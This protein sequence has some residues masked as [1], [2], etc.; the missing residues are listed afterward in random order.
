MQYSITRRALALAALII[1]PQATLI[2]AMGAPGWVRWFSVAAGLVGVALAGLWSWGLARRIKSLTGFV[3][4]L[5][6]L[7]STPPKLKAGNDELGELVH[8]L[9]DVAPQ[10]GEL[11]NQLSTELMR[12]EAILASMTDAIV[13]VDARLNVTFC[14]Q[15]FV[16]V[17]GSQ[18]NI[19]GVALIRIVRDPGLNQVVKR[20]VDSGETI[21]TRLQPFAPGGLAFDIYAAPLATSGWRGAIAILHDVTPLE[22]L[23]RAKRDFVA[24]VSHEFR[25]PLATI[26][27]FAETLLDGGLED[28]ANRRRFVE[29]IQANGAR[30]N[31]I[32]ADLLTLSEIEDGRPGAGARPISI[33]QAIAGA[34]RAIEPAA[35]LMHLNL[36]ADAIPDLYVLGYGIRFEQALL[37]LIDNA[38]K[39]NKEGGEVAVSAG[40]GEGGQMEIRISDTGVGIPQEDLSR[41]FERFYRVDKARSRQVGGTGL[42]LSIVKHAIEQ[43]N[44]TIILESRLGEGSTF[45]VLLPGCAA[46]AAGVLT[47]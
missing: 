29:I 13:A 11:V 19:E 18:A 16:R 38:V 31:H 28:G 17:V 43:M 34:M 40:E 41:V 46:P 7:T 42:G 5:L 21:R 14:N 8:S 10:V 9:S 4:R 35:S 44:G 47:V 27:G 39:F 2:F 25:T 1:L 23:E 32:A 15:A 12:R 30:L 37:N 33:R 22:R 45:R 24:N 36:R 20:V 3:N 26:T 6:D